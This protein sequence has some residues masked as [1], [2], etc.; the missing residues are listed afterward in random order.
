VVGFE[1]DGLVTRPSLLDAL[2][3]TPL[4]SG[5]ESSHGMA[6]SSIWGS[7]SLAPGP[8]LSGF[9]GFDIGE[10]APGKQTPARGRSGASQWSFSQ[11]GTL[12]SIW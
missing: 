4:S 9:P 12:N 7:D 2:S 5:M 11:G 6:G 1:L 10:A 8:G 3:S